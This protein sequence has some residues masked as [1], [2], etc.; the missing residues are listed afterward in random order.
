MIVRRAEDLRGS[1]ADV[2]TE[3]WSSLR[4]LVRDDGL[5]F[6]VTD[7][8]LEPGLDLTLEYRN[9]LEACYCLEGEA[10]MEDLATGEVHPIRPGTLYALDRHD[11]HRIRALSRTRLVCVFTPALAGTEVHDESGSYP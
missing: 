3:H 11:R 6:T 9:H 8:V 5:G 7:T 1:P 10:A 2:R 4:L